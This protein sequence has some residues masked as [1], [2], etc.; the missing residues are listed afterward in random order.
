MFAYK[1]LLQRIVVISTILAG[2][3][4]S[5]AADKIPWLPNLEA[6]RQQAIASQKLIL[7]HFTGEKC[8]PCKR[9]EKNV[10]SMPQ[11]GFTMVQNFAPVKINASASPDIAR[12][13]NVTTWPTDVILAP[14]GHEIHR[15]NSPQEARDYLTVLGQ[16]AWRYRQMMAGS[17]TMAQFTPNAMQPQ[18][19]ANRTPRVPQ[20]NANGTMSNASPYGYQQPQFAQ[21]NMPRTGQSP[22]QR[23]MGGATPFNAGLVAAQQAQQAELAG[24]MKI[25]SATP[26]VPGSAPAQLVGGVNALASQYGATPV[27]RMGYGAQPSAAT[28]SPNTSTNSPIAP[29][30]STGQ[31]PTVGY[32]TPM[33]TTTPV[34]N[35]PTASPSTTTTSAPAAQAAS[36]RVPDSLVIKNE[37]AGR[38]KAAT[39]KITAAAG[40]VADAGQQIAKT[41]DEKAKA[42][43]A[44]ATN[45]EMTTP[46][47][48]AAANSTQPAN[49]QASMTAEIPQLPNESASSSGETNSDGEGEQNLS[50][51]GYC[52][53]TLHEENRWAK[54][55]ARWGARHRGRV[56]LFQSAAAQQQF[57]ADPDR[58]SPILAGYDPVA[59]RDG[60]SLVAGSRNHGVRYDDHMFLFDSE[61]SLQK[62]WSSPEQ[63][64]ATAYQAMHDQSQ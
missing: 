18:V 11:F 30:N 7:V 37:F 46:K 15:M 27:Q 24:N 40:A 50:M 62:F 44:A 38:K 48:S 57:L 54:G 43:A 49:V 36:Q 41:I 26:A 25:P 6:A 55:D 1:N 56:Y 14:S 53:V 20:P 42:V 3:G 32:G 17:G 58:Y 28:A 60:G 31:L 45:T 47:V 29:S 9:L 61:A 52:C 51:D 5:Q 35:V 8:A 34:P 4:S 22:M 2:V 39:E 59:F 19:Q 16:V 10:Y 21:A 33:S 23:A 64:A 12:Q 13:F 63:Y